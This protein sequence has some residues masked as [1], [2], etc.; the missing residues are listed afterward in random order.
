MNYLDIEYAGASLMPSKEEYLE[1]LKQH[2]NWLRGN[3]GGEVAGNFY[4]KELRNLS[5]YD[6]KAKK[7]WKDALHEHARRNTLVH[8]EVILGRAL[9]EKNKNLTS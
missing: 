1:D 6:S 7:G 4:K 9:E 5:E 2:A 8:R 3:Y